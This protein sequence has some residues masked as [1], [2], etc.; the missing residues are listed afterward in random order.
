MKTLFNSNFKF[1]LSCKALPTVIIATA[2]IESHETVKNEY[3]NQSEKNNYET[4]SIRKNRIDRFSGPVLFVRP[5][6][7]LLFQMFGG[8][9]LSQIIQSIACSL[10]KHLQNIECRKQEATVEVFRFIPI[11]LPLLQ[12]SF[13][14]I[15]LYYYRSLVFFVIFRLFNYVVNFGQAELVFFPIKNF[16]KS[17][18]EMLIRVFVPRYLFSGSSSGIG[19]TLGDSILDF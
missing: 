6:E 5:K 10:K 12:N 17:C 16:Y 3:K 15:I 4:I 11:F 14:E 2:I 19:Q 13:S 8:Y 9:I 1:Q 18:F 7:Q